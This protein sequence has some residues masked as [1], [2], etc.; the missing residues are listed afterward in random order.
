MIFDNKYILS[1]YREAINR[2]QNEITWLTN[3][4]RNFGGNQL[5]PLD[6]SKLKASYGCSGNTAGEC[7][8]HLIEFDGILSS[9]DVKYQGCQ[10]LITSPHGSV[11][12][13]TTKF[14]VKQMNY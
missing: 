8:L 9:T 7:Y 4:T 12:L 2:T 6:I 1:C 5:S 14:Q 13:I 11:E 3:P 10:V